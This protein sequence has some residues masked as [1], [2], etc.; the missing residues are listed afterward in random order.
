MHKSSCLYMN[1]D[2]PSRYIVGVFANTRASR[3]RCTR[4]KKKIQDNTTH[5]WFKFLQVDTWYFILGMFK[6]STIL[7]ESFH[8]VTYSSVYNKT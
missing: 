2:F 3:I 8:V 4:G 1:S 6:P 5:C 7:G